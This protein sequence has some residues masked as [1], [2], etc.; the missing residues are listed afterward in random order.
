MQTDKKWPQAVTLTDVGLRDG[1]QI[2]TR[3]VPTAM[4]LELIAALVTAGLKYLQ[5]TAFV[6]PEK[7]PQMADAE[8]LVRRLPPYTGVEFSDR[9]S[10]V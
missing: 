6:H 7:V 9:K 4:K 5:I 2:E 10:V 3:L 8:E 1:I